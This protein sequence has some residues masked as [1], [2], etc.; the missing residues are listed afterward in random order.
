MG[1]G[2]IFRGLTGIG[3]IIE[4][5]EQAVNAARQSGQAVGDAEG[6]IN[7]L[8]SNP[9]SKL[10]RGV[11]QDL[12]GGQV[13]TNDA[14]I[15]NFTK[16]MNLGDLNKSFVNV[17]EKNTMQA[18]PK[19]YNIF[20]NM[21]TKAYVNSG[22]P[23][24]LKQNFRYIDSTGNLVT[25]PMQ[26]FLQ[27]GQ[28][29]N[30][31]QNFDNAV[32]RISISR[33]SLANQINIEKANAVPNQAKIA[34]WQ[35]EMSQLD[36]ESQILAQNK[37]ALQNDWQKSTNA[38]G[39]ASETAFKD[40]QGAQTLG[41]AVKAVGITGA[42]VTTGGWAYLSGQ[43]LENIQKG[44]AASGVQQVQNQFMDMQTQNDAKQPTTPPPLNIPPVSV[45]SDPYMNSIGYSNVLS[46]NKHIKLFKKAQTPPTDDTQSP[47]VNPA[48][49]TAPQQSPQDSDD[50]IQA[51]T[52]VALNNLPNS[53][54]LMS[55]YYQVIRTTLEANGDS[56]TPAALEQIQ[57]KLKQIYPQQVSQ[58]LS[59][60]I[61]K[62]N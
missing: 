55:Q 2:G 17:M 44:G 4:E 43:H 32:K 27:S 31:F 42:A 16:N 6:I 13:P 21:A 59:D 38:I 50:G 29:Q 62:G 34:Q 30:E 9:N 41:N 11:I 35:S 57:N 46:N 10:A 7:A 54:A 3:R 53:E 19:F 47:L 40:V 61:V 15:Q 49:P 48:Q 51:S 25:K 20:Q 26:E 37:Q 45:T 23:S 24:L 8:K 56:L 5:L 36:Q 1:L 18:N 60:P 12:F 39:N 28:I 14:A 22:L 58:I 33:N 52:V